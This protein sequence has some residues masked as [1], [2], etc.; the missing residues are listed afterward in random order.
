MDVNLR[1]GSRVLIEQ[2]QGGGGRLE[3][4]HLCVG[5]LEGKHHAGRAHVC[6]DVHDGID[7]S[8]L[9]DD[10]VGA[11]LQDPDHMLLG[12]R[13]EAKWDRRCTIR[14]RDREGFG[15]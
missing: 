10:G 1:Q 4:V 12:G 14:D 11:A 5:V 7:R 13:V 3:R 9:W 8:D 15:R 6:P 2:R